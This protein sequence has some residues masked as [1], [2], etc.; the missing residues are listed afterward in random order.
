MA[1]DPQPP[2]GWYPDPS[3]GPGRR[4]WDGGAWTDQ[5]A[6]SAAGHPP[7]AVA[8]RAADLEALRAGGRRAK[9]AVLVA[10]PVYAVTPA[11]QGQ[12]IREFRRAFSDLQGQLDEMESGQQVPGVEVRPY[13]PAPLST[14]SSATSL[15]TLVIGVLFVI[16][17]HRAAT[18]A[19]R[20]GRPARRSPGWA[21]G[22]WLIPIGNFFLPYQSARDL[23]RQDEHGRRVVKHWWTAYL[24]AVVVN[25]PLGVIAGFN[26]E[27]PTTIA[28]GALSLVVWLFAAVKAREFIDATN[29]SLTAEL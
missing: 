4:Y 10:V 8:D 12:Q 11:I 5:Y 15:P 26:D 29:E 25:L 23:F 13:T 21:V 18:V 7:A 27:I 1:R 3:G 6:E 16:W 17:F 22:G 20:L 14:L 9:V 24:V 19:L 28:A 2:A